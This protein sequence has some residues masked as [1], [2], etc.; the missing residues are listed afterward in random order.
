MKYILITDLEGNL[1][2]VPLDNIAYVAQ[3]ETVTRIYLQHVAG[4]GDQLW[5]VLTKLS[6]KDVADFINDE[7]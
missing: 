3:Y 2:I 5:C 4:A 1:V 6:V 7:A